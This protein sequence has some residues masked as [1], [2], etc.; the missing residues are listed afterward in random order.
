MKITQE[1]YDKHLKFR[2]KLTERAEEVLKVIRPD[3]DEIWDEVHF[4]YSDNGV[5][6]MARYGEIW[7]EFPSYLLWSDNVKKDWEEWKKKDIV[8]RWRW[9]EEEGVSD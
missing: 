6:Y 5:D 7:G 9:R 8:K 2:A 1:E 3:L 4:S